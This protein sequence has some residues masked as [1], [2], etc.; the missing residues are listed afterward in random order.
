MVHTPVDFILSAALLGVPLPF[1]LHRV[2]NLLLHFLN[3][4]PRL[5]GYLPPAPP[6]QTAHA[7]PVAAAVAA[8]WFANLAIKVGRLEMSSVFEEHASADLL[9]TEGRQ[10]ILFAA[11]VLVGIAGA[12]FAMQQFA[13]GLLLATAGALA[14]RYLFFITVVPLNMALTYVRRLAA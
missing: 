11:F 7:G 8:L 13:I 5:Y 9:L 10:W 14:S 2:T 12:L 4:L 6:L 3:R 1:V